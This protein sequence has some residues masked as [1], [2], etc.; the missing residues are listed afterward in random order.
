LYATSDTALEKAVVEYEMSRLPALYVSRTAPRVIERLL[1]TRSDALRL[2]TLDALAHRE[3]FWAKASILQVLK[4][5][6]DG[7]LRAHIVELIA[8]NALQGSQILETIAADKSD[9]LRLEALRHLEGREGSSA[10]RLLASV[11]RDRSEDMHARVV[12]AHRLVERLGPEVL[13][14]LDQR[15]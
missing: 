2:A 12:A 5:S 8:S 6:T 1:T 9:P 10:E 4:N 14:I 15:T 7:T 3:E 13:E 11:L